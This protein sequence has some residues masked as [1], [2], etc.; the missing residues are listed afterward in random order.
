MNR[1][2]VIAAL[3]LLN[4]GFF[5]AGGC[6][7]KR[8]NVPSAPVVIDMHTHL[9]NARYI[10]LREVAIAF[11]VPTR[12]APILE[13]LIW[14]ICRESDVDNVRSAQLELASVQDE[15]RQIVKW[16]HLRGRFAR[17]R[18][19]NDIFRPFKLSNILTTNE[20]EQLAVY[21]RR[22]LGI[23]ARNRIGS[24]EPSW[25]NI[26]AMLERTGIL[27]D[28]HERVAKA[29]VGEVKG[30]LR[31]AG[32]MLRKEESLAIAVSVTYPQVDLFVHHMMD[33]AGSYGETP[34]IEFTNQVKR[35]LWLDFKTSDKSKGQTLMFAAFDP[36]RRGQAIS[37][38]VYAYEHGAA[39]FKFYPPCGY[40]PAENIIPAPT[41]FPA[42]VLSQWDARY[43]GVTTNDL[44][45][46][47]DEFFAYCQTN[48]I[49]IFLHCT[50]KGFESVEGYGAVMANPVHWRPV[51]KKYP[52]L[53]V[54]FGHSGGW[55][56]WFND[57]K[58]K[59]GG[60]NFT[61]EVIQLCATYD[62]VY[63]ELGYLEQI[64]SDGGVG[65]LRAHLKTA[66]NQYPALTNKV[67]YGTDWH[68]LVQEDDCAQYLNRF[69]KV[70]DRDS[71]TK[72]NLL[73]YKSA[74]F[75]GNASRYLRLA[76]LSLDPRLKKH[77]R[78]RL[79]EIVARIQRDSP[80]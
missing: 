55:C 45:S 29:S 53:R 62:N 40:R 70:F 35:L 65:Y 17:Q 47:N 68:M 67:M 37:N 52:K 48:D 10:P 3:L 54:C 78:D 1:Q 2:R 51:F 36:F 30:L 13:K 15:V 74:F 58:N 44:N 33:L 75:A 6:A 27:A 59:C 42:T 49:P 46:W 18:I 23:G 69:E 72:D 21:M 80:P 60:T 8:P 39:G 5:L 7:T 63:C 34:Q 12:I 79:A 20:I 25:E 9:F 66:F 26:A 76:D 43:K 61:A 73:K 28:S 56:G 22:D 32:T 41:N 31:L 57:P 16:S 38:A 11:G 4:I 19:I 24:S 77:V 71:D 14:E 64:L 50:P